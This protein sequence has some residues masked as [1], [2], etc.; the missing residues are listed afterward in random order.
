MTLHLS[1][2]KK[3]F[4][5]FARDI[6]RPSREVS[7]ERADTLLWLDKNE[8]CDPLY[9]NFIFKTLRDFPSKALLGYPDCYILYKKLALQL[10]VEIN[11]L[12][13]AAG[14]DGV[15]RTV[16]ETFV[17]PGDSVIYTDP[18]FAMYAIYAQMFGAQ[19]HVVNYEGS[20]D[21]PMLKAATIIDAIKNVQPKLI[22]LP[23]PNSPTGTVFAPQE[24]REII[25]VA[26]NVGAVILIDEA[27]YPFYNQTVMHHINDY[28][29]LIVARTFSKAWGCAGLRIGYGVANHELIRECHKMRPMYETGALSITLAERLLDFEKEMLASVDRLNAGKDYFLAEMKKLGLRTFRCQGNFLHVDFDEYTQAIHEALTDIVLYRHHFAHPSLS[30]FSRFTATTQELFAPIVKI[31]S[32]IIKG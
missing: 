32:R 2:L 16:Y 22:G 6:V 21:G 8:N 9:T 18:T 17:A 11:E 13:L 14:S 31:I 3:P 1:S 12:I 28:P 7:E 29:H 5:A 19:S 24:L 30:G 10:N 23:N 4:P 27:Y 26:G 15:I 25:E 20:A